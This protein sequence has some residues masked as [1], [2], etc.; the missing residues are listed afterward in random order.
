MPTFS[1]LFYPGMQLRRRLISFI[2]QEM[3]KKVLEGEGEGQGQGHKT[4]VQYTPSITH[5]ALTNHEAV[6]NRQGLPQRK[7]E[8]SFSLNNPVKVGISF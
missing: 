8:H 3:N 7:E 1:R 5:P 2:T 6:E 4:E